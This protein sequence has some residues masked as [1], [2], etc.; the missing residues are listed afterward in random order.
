[1]MEIYLTTIDER[2]WQCVLTGYTPPI[3]IDKDGVESPKPIREQ[4]NDKLDASEYN[5]KGLNTNVNGVYVLQHQLVSRC[6]TSKATWDIL[7]NTFE[8]NNTVKLSK[9]QKLTSNF[10]SLKMHEY[11]VNIYV[12]IMLIF[13]ITNKIKND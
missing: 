13:I 12:S 2:V 10:E 5:A 4:T 1:M 11:D 9:L 3:K 6:K 8:G 7:Q